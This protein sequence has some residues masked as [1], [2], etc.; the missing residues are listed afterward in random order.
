MRLCQSAHVFEKTF[1]NGSLAGDAGK[2]EDD[3]VIAHNNQ[4][5]RSWYFAN[6]IRLPDVNTLMTLLEAPALPGSRTKDPA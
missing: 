3:V 2:A 6:Q 5:G 4:L 1:A